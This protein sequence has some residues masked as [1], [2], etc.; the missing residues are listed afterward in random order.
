MYVNAGRDTLA[1]AG[2]AAAAR[3]AEAGVHVV[4][5]TCAYLTPVIHDVDA[6]LMT[7]SAKA[8]WYAPANLGV[9]V[10]FG[11]TE[12]C[13]RS[14]AAGSIRRDEELWGVG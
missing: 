9:D 5:D 11:T 7:D 1:G 8:A 10:V 14:A 13:V 2:A 3:L 12:E 6:P 4:T